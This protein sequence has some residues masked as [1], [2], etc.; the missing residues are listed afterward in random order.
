MQGDAKAEFQLGVCCLVGSAG[1]PKDLARANALFA[2]SAAIGFLKAQF[3]LGVSYVY[4]HGV[5]MDEE[6]G[7]ELIKEAANQDNLEALRFLAVHSL[8]IKKDK[9]EA[10]EQLSKA[11]KLNDPVS[12]LIMGQWYEKGTA[13]KQD[14]VEAC[15]W[16]KKA[17]KQGNKNA[18]AVLERLA[19]SGHYFSFSTREKIQGKWYARV[20]PFG[21]NFIVQ[22]KGLWGIVDSQNNIKLPIKYMRVHWEIE[23]TFINVYGQDMPNIHFKIDAKKIRRLYHLL[24]EYIE[25]SFNEMS[26]LTV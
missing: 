9:Y 19:K 14:Y 4:G 25:L 2:L 16:Y 10:I 5:E 6:K 22:S 7:L 15:R 20:I 24:P 21:N 26:R 17:A 13:V 18:K 8:Y 1:L 11:V 23:D 12:Q 3:N